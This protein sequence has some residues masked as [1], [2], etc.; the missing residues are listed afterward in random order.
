M[1][2][3]LKRRNISVDNRK[4][5]TTIYATVWK[6]FTYTGLELSGSDHN[7]ILI[8]EIW[9]KKKDESLS[10]TEVPREP[11]I[12]RMVFLWHLY[13]FYDVTSCYLC[14]NTY[15]SINIWNLE[16]KI[17]NLADA[18]L[19]QEASSCGIFATGGLWVFYGTLYGFYDVTR[20]YLCN[21]TYISINIWNLETKIIPWEF[22]W[23]IFATGDFY[24]GYICNRRTLVFL[25]HL[26]W[27]LWCYK[28]LFV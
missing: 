7:R 21:N 25:L 26:V 20:F 15:I 5:I 3:Y 8:Y 13:G 6:L 22:S 14:N 4:R 17:W 2:F 9:K 1:F 23:C 16:K 27:F 28:M 19:Q 11:N 10:G 24:L 12:I 18:Y